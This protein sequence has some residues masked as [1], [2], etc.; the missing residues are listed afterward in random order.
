MA[1]KCQ[2]GDKVDR[3]ILGVK[4]HDIPWIEVYR[5]TEKAGGLYVTATVS[6]ENS[7][8]SLVDGIRHRAGREVEIELYTG[9]LGNCP[10]FLEECSGRTVGGVF[11]KIHMAQDV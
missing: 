6:S 7:L 3:K 10:N 9:R 5:P 4:G 2:I 11:D 1:E 8:K